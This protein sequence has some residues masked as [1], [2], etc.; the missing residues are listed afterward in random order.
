MAYRD[1]GQGTLI[2]VPGLCRKFNWSVSG[3]YLTQGR[4]QVAQRL[5]GTAFDGLVE[6]P[7]GHRLTSVDVYVTSLCNRRCTYCFLPS[8]FFASGLRM[9]LEAFSGIVS[10]RRRQNIRELTFLGGEPSLHPSFPEM[11]SLAR[12]GGPGLLARGRRRPPGALGGAQSMCHF[13]DGTCIAL[14]C[15]RRYQDPA[16]V[17]EY[18]TST[19]R[20]STTRTMAPRSVSKHRDGL[21]VAPARPS[22][23]PLPDAI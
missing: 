23:D 15:S 12:K 9:S 3:R 11:I 8:D 7:P 13:P 16:A 21:A 20:A 19:Q 6:L 4:Y 1:A 17:G 10:W 14:V 2:P 22:T 5:L 18:R